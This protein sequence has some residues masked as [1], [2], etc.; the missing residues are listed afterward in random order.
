MPAPARPRD[1]GL[2]RLTTAGGLQSIAA[3]AVL[4]LAGP[5]WAGAWPTPAGQTQAILKY[6]GATADEAY[7]PDGLVVPITERTEESLSLFVERGL[8]ERIT[9]Q[10]KVAYARGEDQFVGYSGRG[11]VE[12]GLRYALLKERTAVSLYAGAVIAGEGRNAGYAAPGAGEADLELRLLAGR[13][14]AL[15]RR[16]LFAEVQVARLAREGLPDETR[17]DT[18]I[19]WEPFAGWLLLSQTYAG[20]AEADPVAPM[21]LKNELGVV[22]RFGDWRVQAGWRRST[23]GVE[24]PAEQGPVLA[25]WA[26]F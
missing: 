17:I 5:A 2:R 25:L 16:P 10:G 20:R 26:T 4:L 19:G 3:L 13:S 7:D 8:T 18:T 6:E 22:R 14:G 21:W 15:W 1:A 23:F 24:S 11:P 12:L 9:F